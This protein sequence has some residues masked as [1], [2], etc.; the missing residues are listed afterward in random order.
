MATLPR[1]ASMFT[2]ECATL[3]E[4]VNV[5]AVFSDS[6]GALPTRLFLILELDPLTFLS[7]SPR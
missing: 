3:G 4:T 5:V 2:A 1:M 7:R 6:R